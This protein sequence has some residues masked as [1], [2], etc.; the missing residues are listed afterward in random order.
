MLNVAQL[1]RDLEAKRT[2]GLALATK[3]HT[4]ANDEDRLLTEEETTEIEAVLKDGRGL[5]AKIDRLK[6]GEAMRTALDQLTA[7]APDPPVVPIRNLSLGTQWA[8]NPEVMDF[9]KKQH[10]RTSTAWRSPSMELAV[11]WSRKAYATT[12][13][14]D[15]AS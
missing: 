5:K 1:E 6:S 15:P 4:A 10:H 3:Y 2:Q 7:R 12:L 11:D 8:T 9:F 13:T 14:T